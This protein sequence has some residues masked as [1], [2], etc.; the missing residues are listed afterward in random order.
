M[1]ASLKDFLSK[2]KLQSSF[3]FHFQN[4]STKFREELKRSVAIQSPLTGT[5]TGCYGVFFPPTIILQARQ[6]PG[7]NPHHRRNMT[8]ISPR[9]SYN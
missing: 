1:A 2:M 4:I 6:P 9:H 7:E 8:R 3:Y 5:L